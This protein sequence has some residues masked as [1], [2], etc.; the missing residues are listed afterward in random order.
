MAKKHSKALASA[1]RDC[2]PVATGNDDT[3]RHAIRQWRDDVQAVAS[4]CASDNPKFEKD[5]FLDA[6]GYFTSDS[7][8]ES[9]M[10]C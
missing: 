1:L 7:Q 6:C 3:L 2:K 5:R 10:P 9:R 8:V 4:V